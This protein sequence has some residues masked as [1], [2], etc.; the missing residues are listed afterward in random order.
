MTL[1]GRRQ[2]PAGRD[3][4]AKFKGSFA[5][6]GRGTFRHINGNLDANLG[7]PESFY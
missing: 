1:P 7:M 2:P 3:L 4:V 5:S 6:K